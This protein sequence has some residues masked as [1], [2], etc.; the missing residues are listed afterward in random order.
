MV[1]AVEGRDRCVKIAI[2]VSLVYASLV[3]TSYLKVTMK[4]ILKKG[5]VKSTF[6]YLCML[7]E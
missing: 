4:S 2:F 1:Y 6:I 3:Q 7:F 5:K